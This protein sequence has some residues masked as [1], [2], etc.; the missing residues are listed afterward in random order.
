MHN[1]K[2]I[3]GIYISKYFKSHEKY[4]KIPIIL[5]TAHQNYGPKTNYVEESGADDYLSK[6]LQD[7]NI[8]IEK[9]ERLV[10]A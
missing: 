9:I 10:P 4:S 5:V 2:K 1:N 7:F 8:I 6:P 3:D